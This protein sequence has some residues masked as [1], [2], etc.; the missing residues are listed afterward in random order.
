MTSKSP[1]ASGSARSATAP[2]PCRRPTT[3]TR[4]R[5]IGRHKIQQ[6]AAAVAAWERAHGIGA[7][8]LARRRHQRGPRP[9]TG[10]RAA[11][12]C[13]TTCDRRQGPLSAAAQ[14]PMIAGNGSAVEMISFG[15]MFV[16]GLGALLVSCCTAGTAALLVLASAL[17][18]ASDRLPRRW[19]RE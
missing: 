6:V 14:G 7:A 5:A 13:G 19:L 11:S 3:A 4:G 10:C 16:A 17:S 18:G 1:T 9:W 12:C 2:T 15:R 8:Q